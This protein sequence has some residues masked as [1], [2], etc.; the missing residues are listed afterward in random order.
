M[1]SKHPQ[2]QF[3]L[4]YIEWKLPANLI[5][6]DWSITYCQVSQVCISK[7]N[8][9]LYI[10][11]LTKGFLHCILISPD[12]PNKIIINLVSL[13]GQKSV[14]PD[15]LADLQKAP[16]LDLHYFQKRE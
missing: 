11:L 13:C 16:D 6:F 9:T 12:K 1:K 5:G 7:Y 8:V 3:Y 2:T 14:D 4:F 10:C 15:Q